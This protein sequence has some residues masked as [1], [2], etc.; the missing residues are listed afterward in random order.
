MERPGGQASSASSCPAAG[1][2][3]VPG[4]RVP[5]RGWARQTHTGV[6]LPAF[7][8]GPPSPVGQVRTV[9]PIGDPRELNGGRLVYAQMTPFPPIRSH[10]YFIQ[11]LNPNPGKVSSP[12]PHGPGAFPS[13][14]PAFLSGP[15]SFKPQ[16]SLAL[17]HGHSFRVSLMWN[18]WQ[19]SCSRQASW[20]QC[21]PAVPTF[22]CVCPSRLS[23]PGRAPGWGRPRARGR[24]ADPGVPLGRRWTHFLRG[25]RPGFCPLP[26]A[27]LSP[28][29]PPSLSP[30]LFITPPP[31]PP[32]SLHLSLL[33]TAKPCWV[34]G[35]E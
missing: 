31:P 4:S 7:S 9:P 8:G 19:S 17:S 32:P 1:G 16:L 11:C 28:S 21:V 15:C 3:P 14:C 10:V 33:H 29:L 23:W 35:T 5:V 18:T 20:R 34:P 25:L 30:S 22:L 2:Q 13:T 6:S 24:L 12:P 27:A 26:R